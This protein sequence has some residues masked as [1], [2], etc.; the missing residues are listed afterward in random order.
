MPGSTAAALRFAGAAGAD[1]GAGDGG[2]TP[3][4]IAQLLAIAERDRLSGAAVARRIGVDHALLVRARRE[5]PRRDR[6]GIVTCAKI[7]QAYP[8]LSDAAAHYL[9]AGFGWPVVRALAALGTAAATASIE[10]V[11]PGGDA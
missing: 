1:L 7:V 11:P 6:L 5:G 4:L 10:A 9:A 2:E 8:E 3:D